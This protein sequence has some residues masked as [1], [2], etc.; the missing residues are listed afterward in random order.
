MKKVEYVVNPVQT[1]ACKQARE[2]LKLMRGEDMSY[3]VLA[4]HGTKSENIT[5]IVEN[6][7]KVPGDKG[8]K[9]R[10]DSGD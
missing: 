8:F 10:T 4:F 3:P 9:H 1:K 2:D 7:F 5:P 6:G